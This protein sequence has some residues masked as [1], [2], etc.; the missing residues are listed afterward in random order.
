MDIQA[1]GLIVNDERP[2][3]QFVEDQGQRDQVDRLHLKLSKNLRISIDNELRF[4]PGGPAIPETPE[5][6]GEP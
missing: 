2:W 1:L 4:L 3:S 5:I 6:P